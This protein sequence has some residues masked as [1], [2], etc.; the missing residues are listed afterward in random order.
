MSVSLTGRKVFACYG[1]QCEVF[2]QQMQRAVDKFIAHIVQQISS[3]KVPVQ[4]LS[5]GISGGLPDG[6]D[7]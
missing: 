2:Y 1:L 7:G 6:Y 5:N 3:G 4:D